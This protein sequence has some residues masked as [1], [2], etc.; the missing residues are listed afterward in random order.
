M[1]NFSLTLFDVLSFLFF[2][3]VEFLCLYVSFNEF[4]FSQVLDKTISLK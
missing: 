1:M 4:L 3:F 2:N